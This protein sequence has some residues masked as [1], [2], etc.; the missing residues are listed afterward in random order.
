MS[1]SL[2]PDRMIC[3][4]CYRGGRE[5]F[6]IT[7]AAHSQYEAWIA[8][9][10]VRHQRNHAM[11]LSLEEPQEIADAQ[12]N[13]RNTLDPVA[14]APVIPARTP[15]GAAVRNRPSLSHVESRSFM[16]AL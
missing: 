3:V 12:D 11:R 13:P 9:D 16:A 5:R 4:Q 8:I 15:W 2:P 7:D 1:A 14:T 6:I 10:Q